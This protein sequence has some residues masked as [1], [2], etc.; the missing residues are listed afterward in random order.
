MAAGAGMTGVVAVVSPDAEARV[1]AVRGAP[2]GAEIAVDLVRKGVVR[3]VAE[4]AVVAVATAGVVTDEAAGSGISA[5][6][7]VRTCPQSASLR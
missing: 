1:G 3:I 7:P 4:I 5:T 6:V 2:A